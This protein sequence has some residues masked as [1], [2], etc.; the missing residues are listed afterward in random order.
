MSSNWVEMVG[1]RSGVKEYNNACDGQV[2]TRTAPPPRTSTCQP[3]E[4]L[5]GRDA[6]GQRLGGAA[7]LSALK[8]EK[9]CETRDGRK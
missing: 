1:L 4:L 2:V 9:S 8:D 3:L 5:T 6:A 7:L